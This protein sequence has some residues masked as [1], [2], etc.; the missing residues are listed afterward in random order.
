MPIEMI[1]GDVEEHCGRRMKLL[2]EI[3]LKARDLD[4]QQVMGLADRVGEGS[5]DVARRQRSP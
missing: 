3:E 4:D 5:A 1:G 2:G